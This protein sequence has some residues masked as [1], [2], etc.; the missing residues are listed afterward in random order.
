[1]LSPPGISPPFLPQPEGGSADS[2]AFHPTEPSPHP[3]V[4]NTLPL[5]PVH[6]LA[7]TE[8]GVYRI[9]SVLGE[10]GMGVVY[11][12]H[13]RA[14][15]RT[16][17]VKCL[18]ANLA[19]NAEIRRRFSREAR[20]LRSWAHE[21]VVGVYDF[22]ELEHILGIVMEFIDGLTLVQ[23][24]TRWRGRVPYREV[25]A[26]FG[27]V[28]DAMEEGHRRGIIHRDLKPDNILVVADEVGLRPKIVDFGIAK[29]LEGTTYTLSGAFLGTCSYM[30][31][32]QVKQPQ[33]ADARSDIYSLGI[34]LYQL[35]T[36]RVPFE[37]PNHFS[38]MM[39]HVTDAP[40]PPSA[41]RPDVPPE[42]EQLILDALAKDPSGRPASCAIFRQRLDAALADHLPDHVQ[43]DG[44][45]VP[46]VLRGSHGEEMVLVPS[47]LFLM[48][49]QRRKVH[50]D[51]F[52]I[53]RTPVTNRQFKLFVEV[54]GYK[55][56]DQN[57]S[58]F[59]FQMRRGEIPKGLEDHPV[60]YVSWEDARAYAAWAGKRLP[61]EAEWE[62]A[63]RG[64]DGRRYPWGRAE[65]TP[66]LANFD[67]RSR[68]NGTSAVGA[69]PEAA[70]PYGALDMAGNVWEWCDD[71]D[72]PD[73]YA[74]GPAR[75]P[76]NNR[77]PARNPR[78]VMRGGSWMYGAQSLRAYTRQ[79]YDARYRFADGG[80][81]CA[82][83]ASGR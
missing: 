35:V 9:E 63:A 25:R 28:L 16:V 23:H 76:R 21:H 78:L 46:P 4:P 67:N 11:R 24:V 7:G 41:H 19:G 74:D 71:Y 83:S 32:E 8:L 64:T 55:P 5:P 49:Q 51:A 27:G 56:E 48:G 81:R 36:G 54:T 58:R 37:N 33:S 42:L 43:G 62:K 40:S 2:L 47:G 59:L 39:A 77:P 1:M 75:N 10:G 30:S 50:L 60:T 34:T 68:E 80:F 31:P 12:A 52:Y 17:A 20:V 45:E 66:R 6:L 29:I 13:D 61:S 3:G 38:V 14:R 53:D 72:D 79:S 15:D 70:S 73:F 69:Y 26:V 18:H 44:R 65:P 82:R 22:V 57:A